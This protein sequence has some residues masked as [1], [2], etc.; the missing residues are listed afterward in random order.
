MVT[1]VI[2]IYSQ[3]NTSDYLPPGIQLMLSTCIMPIIIKFAKM[4]NLIN[5]ICMQDVS[6]KYYQKK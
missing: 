1:Y 4:S 3:N 2:H 5:N 6:M